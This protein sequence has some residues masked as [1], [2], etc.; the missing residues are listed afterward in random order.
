VT[1]SA[2]EFGGLML[3]NKAENSFQE[4]LGFIS[5]GVGCAVWIYS[6]IDIFRSYKKYDYNL[7]LKYNISVSL[8]SIIFS[9]EF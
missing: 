7:K 5:Y 3:V 1:I 8:N 9:Y 4:S 2:T 6:I